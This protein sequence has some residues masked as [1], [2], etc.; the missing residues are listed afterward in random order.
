MIFPHTDVTFTLARKVE[1]LERAKFE[2]LLEN[3]ETDEASINEVILEFASMALGVEAGLR[4]LC[5]AIANFGPEFGQDAK[6]RN[7]GGSGLFLLLLYL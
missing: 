2:L 4:T 1:L 6:V 3:A 7:R 5:D